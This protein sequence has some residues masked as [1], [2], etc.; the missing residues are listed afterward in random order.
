[1]K[2]IPFP[3]VQ[4]WLVASLRKNPLYALMAKESPDSKTRQCMEIPATVDAALWIGLVLMGFSGLVACKASSASG[5]AFCL[6]LG[7]GTW[8]FAG[9]MAWEFNVKK[10]AIP[11]FLL[12]HWPLEASALLQ[13]AEAQKEKANLAESLPP[14]AIPRPV[15]R[16]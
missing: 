1:M 15:R 13:E 2:I 5:T 8:V 4:G 9:A 6:G 14:A 3:L 7:I 10:K 11:A 16:L 12:A